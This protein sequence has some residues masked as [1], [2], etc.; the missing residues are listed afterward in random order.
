[1]H[2]TPL[3]TR[4]MASGTRVPAVFRPVRWLRYAATPT[5]AAMA[6]VTAIAGNGMAGMLCP[7]TRAMP[8]N[9]MLA[10]YVLMAVFHSVPWL[11]LI[12][13]WRSGANASL[14]H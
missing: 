7:A 8:W 10:M 4:P 5:F 9:D 12:A 6:L 3:L 2:A 14:S 1:M 13:A 11:K